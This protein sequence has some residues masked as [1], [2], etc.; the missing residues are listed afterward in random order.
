MEQ[1]KGRRV[2]TTRRR[3]QGE[4]EEKSLFF[5]FCLGFSSGRTSGRT[6][7]RLG[8]KGGRGEGGRVLSM[9]KI[10]MEKGSKAK[11]R[12]FVDLILGWNDSGGLMRKRPESLTE[13]YSIVDS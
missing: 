5:G 10:W 3:R 4:R 12:R 2:L 1:V 13:G 9:T 7:E 11:K 6:E 8:A